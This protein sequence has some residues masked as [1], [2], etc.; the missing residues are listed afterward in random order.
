[1]ALCRLRRGERRDL[2]YVLAMRTRSREQLTSH[3][4]R[5]RGRVLAAALMCLSAI[6]DAV[7]DGVVDKS[8]AG[9]P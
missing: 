3:R 4:S 9:Q 5:G 7:K 1:V 2:R 8:G 6:F